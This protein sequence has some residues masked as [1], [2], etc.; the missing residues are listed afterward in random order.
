MPFSLVVCGIMCAMIV[1][2]YLGHFCLQENIPLENVV[3]SG[4]E[5]SFNVFPKALTILP[6]PNLWVFLF[7]AAMIFLGIDTQFGFL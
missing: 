3:V 1:F 5:L 6:F 7:F 4:P 2:M